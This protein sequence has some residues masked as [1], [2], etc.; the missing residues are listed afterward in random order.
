MARPYFTLISRTVITNG[1]GSKS[2]HWCPEFGDYDKAVVEDE[3][4]D[5]RDHHEHGGIKT[6]IIRTGDKQADID[7]AVA[8]L[9]GKA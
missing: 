5:F 3:E 6:R 9:T 1:D 2:Y 8:K 4:R 7:A